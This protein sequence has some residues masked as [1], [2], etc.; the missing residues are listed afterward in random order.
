MK[1]LVIQSMLFAFIAIIGSSI[2]FPAK[3]QSKAT[4]PK[5]YAVI[6][7]TIPGTM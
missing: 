5:V 1:K 3:T 2:I 6:I 7:N 4:I